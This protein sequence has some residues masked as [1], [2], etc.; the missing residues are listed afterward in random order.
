MIDDTVTI[1]GDVVIKTGASQLMCIEV[2]KTCK[3]YAISQQCGLFRV[4]KVLDYDHASG[5]AKFEFIH[6]IKALREITAS[7]WPPESFLDKLGRSLAVIHKELKLPDD[8]VIPLAKDYCLAGSEVVAPVTILAPTVTIAR[9][10][11]NVLQGVR[12]A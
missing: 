11:R 10:V 4:P 7:G 8:M 6:N 3:A 2:E 5:T 1:C 9:K 12:A